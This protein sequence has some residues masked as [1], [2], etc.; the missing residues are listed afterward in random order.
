VKFR[1]G[2]ARACASGE[3]T[4]RTRVY[5]IIRLA[6]WT[7]AVVCVCFMARNGDRVRPSP[8]FIVLYGYYHYYH[9][10]LRIRIVMRFSTSTIPTMCTCTMR[11][12]WVLYCGACAAI[13]LRTLCRPTVRRAHVDKSYGSDYYNAWLPETWSSWWPLYYYHYN[14][15]SQ[16]NRRSR[17][18][19]KIDV[20]NPPT[21]I[22]SYTRQHLIS[23]STIS[24]IRSRKQ[25]D[26]NII[27]EN[28]IGISRFSKSNLRY[29]KKILF[30]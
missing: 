11:C 22:Q 25:G 4:H 21:S 13:K 16:P 15:Q 5:Y 17:F 10:H 7:V 27:E 12:I 26:N 23:C 2:V 19:L 28:G 30:Y 20:G 18:V 29:Q 8:D 6:V 1:D 14:V 9:H 3:T 24:Y